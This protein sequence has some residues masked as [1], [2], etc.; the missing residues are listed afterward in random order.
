[1][2]FVGVMTMQRGR[3][4]G[5][6]S[7]DDVA[8]FARMAPHLERAFELEYRIGAETFKTAAAADL[9]DTSPLGIV[10]LDRRGRIVFANRAACAMAAA[11]EAFTLAADGIRALRAPDDAVLQRLIGGT[12]RPTD[13]IRAARGGAL[14]L[15]RRSG[16]HD[17]A[18]L[19]TPLPAATGL[20]SRLAPVSCVLIT[21]PEATTVP[22]GDLLHQLYRLT[23]A[24]I[25]VAE[26]LA[27]GDPPKRIAI[28]LNIST[29]T[30]REHLRALYRKTETA[31]QAD[32]L[33]LL[34]RLPQ[35]EAPAP[36]SRP[37][38]R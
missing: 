11:T 27:A 13:D 14:R 36:P 4:S 25:R 31:G 17:Y 5:H 24:E 23:P 30:A 6:P 1:M 22:A 21:D 37:H 8:L 28:T 33:G 10:M 29:A 26:R 20:F 12:V 19:V 15:P 3:R 7:G 32:L 34:L 9:L 38:R 18:L 2:P 16:R 35:D